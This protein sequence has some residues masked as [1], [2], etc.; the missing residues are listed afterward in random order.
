MYS[1]ITTIV[2]DP[3]QDQ[4]SLTA[5][6]EFARQTNAHLEVICLAI[7]AAPVEVVGIMGTTIPSF[8][9]QES[10]DLADEMRTWAIAEAK[11]Y[12]FVS[13][14]PVIVALAGVDHMISRFTRYS[15]I[16]IAA[17]RAE[18]GSN[19]SIVFDALLT[20]AKAPVF[21]TCNGTLD[22]SKIKR[23]VIAWDESD[24]SLSAAKH[25]L[26]ILTQCTDVD[27][28]MVSPPR[29]E[30]DQTD[31]GTALLTMLARNKVKSRLH[32]LPQTLPTVADQ[33]QRFASDTDA[34][35]IV[36]GS[37]GHSPLRERLLGGVTRDMIRQNSRHLLLGT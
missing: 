2:T 3:K 9:I 22:P 34:D 28:I 27:V 18:P 6:L 19:S 20:S 32:L 21:V 8:S 37:Y 13:V 7:D 25:A 17:H 31:P 5:A 16:V 30:H 36:M 29:H 11:D 26:P 4:D 14:S 15:D 33:I 12:S 24:K 1:T 23:A 10:Q 35:L